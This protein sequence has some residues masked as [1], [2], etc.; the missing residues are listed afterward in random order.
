MEENYLVSV[1]LI[2]CNRPVAMLQRSLGSVIC[3]TFT[4]YE[5]VVVNTN[6]DAALVKSISDYV[7]SLNKEN[8]SILHRPGI[9][10]N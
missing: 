1:I 8:I 9:N 3:Q 4:D 6:K 7:I 5:I 10:N 2:T